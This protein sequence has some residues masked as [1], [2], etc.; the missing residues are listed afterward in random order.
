MMNYDLISLHLVV[1]EYSVLLTMRHEEIGK[2]EERGGA[3]NHCWQF[4]S[5]I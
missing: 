5:Q 4:Q 3:V 2:V 1:I